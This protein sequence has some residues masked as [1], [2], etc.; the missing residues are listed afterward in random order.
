MLFLQ[1]LEN[2]SINRSVNPFVSNGGKGWPDGFLKC[3]PTAPFAY[4][5]FFL[6]AIYIAAE[7]DPKYKQ[8]GDYS[9]DRRHRTVNYR[10]LAQVQKPA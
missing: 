7:T 10:P 5:R 3:P 9:P 1:R 6:G 2:E 8:S 4:E